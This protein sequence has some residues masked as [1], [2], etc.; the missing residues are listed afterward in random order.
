MT[1]A[2]FLGPFLAVLGACASDP[3]TEVRIDRLTIPSVLLE[4]A[5]SPAVPPKPRDQ[6]A[7]GRYIVALHEA[8]ADCKSR[9]EAIRD[10]QKP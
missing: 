7:V 9:V 2:L 5:P 8:H 10:L 3:L 1:R 4:C 6:E